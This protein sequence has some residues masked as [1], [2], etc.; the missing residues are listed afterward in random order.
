MHPHGVRCMLNALRMRSGAN[1]CKGPGNPR[2]RCM[3]TPSNGV[4]V[5]VV[6]RTV[7]HPK[8][9]VRQWEEDPDAAAA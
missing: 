7:H 4:V 1:C 5:I 2:V 6:K 3:T 8:S 9:I